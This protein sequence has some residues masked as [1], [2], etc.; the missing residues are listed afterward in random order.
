MNESPRWLVEKNR[1]SEARKALAFVRA[2]PEDHEDVVRELEEIVEDF[3]GHEKMP[4]VQQM[5]ATW[6]DKRTS[7]TFFMAIALMAAQ[8]WT[9]TNSINYYAPQVRHLK[10]EMST[11]PC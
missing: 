1:L 11:V 6:S 7:Y 3:N 9:G 5:K 4:L 10:C 2:K 8:Q